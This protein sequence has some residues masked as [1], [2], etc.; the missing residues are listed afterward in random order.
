M[1]LPRS[2]ASWLLPAK[3]RITSSRVGGTDW[4]GDGDVTEPG[5]PGLGVLGRRVKPRVAPTMS[6]GP[7]WGK[8]RIDLGTPCSK[9]DSF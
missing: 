9:S 3:A 1:V 5:P 6:V 7:V 4:A 2:I 8:L